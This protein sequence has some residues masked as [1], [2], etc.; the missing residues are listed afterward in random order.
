MYR[1]VYSGYRCN[2]KNPFASWEYA[3][4]IYELQYVIKNWHGAFPSVEG[5]RMVLY[6]QAVY[7]S[8]RVA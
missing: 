7:L 1:H 6:L 8:V 4:S 5:G 2:K 3:E